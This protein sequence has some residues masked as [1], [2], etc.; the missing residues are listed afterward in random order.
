[1]LAEFVYFCDKWFG[2]APDILRLYSVPSKLVEWLSPVDSFALKVTGITEWSTMHS[3][4][5]TVEARFNKVQGTGKIGG[6]LF[7]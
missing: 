6:S 1:M 4:W 7:I 3:E 2:W 5:S